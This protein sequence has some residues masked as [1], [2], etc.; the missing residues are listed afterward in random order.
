MGLLLSSAVS[1]TTDTVGDATSTAGGTHVNVY[2]MSLIASASGTLQ[3]IGANIYY[4]SGGNIV[5]GIYADNGGVPGARLAISTPRLTSAGWND[6]DVSGAGVNIVA[7]TKY[8]IA[9]STS[10]SNAI[11][12]NPANNGIYIAHAYDGSLPN[13][14]GTPTGV[15][16]KSNMRITYSTTTTTTTTAGTTTTTT[17]SSTTTTAPTTTTTTLP[18]TTSLWHQIAYVFDLPNLRQ[19]LYINGQPVSPTGYSLA[20]GDYGTAQWLSVGVYRPDCT[21]ATPGAAYDEYAIYNRALTRQEVQQ[22]Y[23][24]LVSPGQLAT[25]KFLT[26]TPLS[27]GTHTIKLCTASACQTGYLTIA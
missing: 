25:V 22:L 4:I 20:S 13:P 18:P 2:T 16:V 9:V 12:N 19:W 27:P 15:T 11:Y 7:T 3:T 26:P 1:A 24:G 5:I 21:D 8:W 6:A 23:S 10:M 14:Y 17:A